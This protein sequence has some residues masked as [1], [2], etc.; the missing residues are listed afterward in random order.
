[1]TAAQDP[2]SPSV[3][4][5]LDHLEHLIAAGKRLPFTSGTLI[6]EVETLEII[7]RARMSLPEDLVRAHQTV[8]D[9][10]GILAAA[11]QEAGYVVTTARSEAE[12]LVAQAHQEVA[13]LRARAEEEAER[14]IQEAQVQAEGLTSEHSIVQTAQQHASQVLAQ[15]DQLGEKARAE[16]DEYA[17]EVMER[18]EDQLARTLT[19]V[20]KGIE[21]LPTPPAPRRRK[22]A[23]D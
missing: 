12:A 4:S 9:R 2:R 15:A 20:R 19:T 22:P 10:E 5:L 17:R 21:T 3:V 18:L 6:N 8:L 16:A 7:D 14:L 23:R 1:M 13:Q 11:D